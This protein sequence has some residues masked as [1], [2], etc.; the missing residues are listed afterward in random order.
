M[1]KTIKIA[2]YS[3]LL[4]GCCAIAAG[5]TTYLVNKNNKSI[6]HVYVTETAV[7]YSGV[8]SLSMSAA[9]RTQPV[10]LTEA[11]EMTVHG[12]VHIKATVNGRTQTI[13]ETPDIFEY[14]F[15]F[16][17]PRQRQIQS[18][19]QVGYGSGVILSKDG[20][21][22][23]NNHVIDKADDIEVTLNDSRV[24]H[25]SLVGKDENTDLAL[26]KI[27]GDEFPVIPM[28]NSD[29]LKLGE[30]VLAVGNPFNLTSSVTAG[31][32]SA[33]ARKIGIYEGSESIESFIQT[34]A[35]INMGNS[36]G[37]LVNVKGELVGINSALE[38][39]TGTYAGYGFAI[40]TTIVRKVVSDLK[41]YGSV[42][43]AILGIRGGDV[44][45]MRQLDENKEKDFGTLE[46]VYVSEVSDG[47]GALA[48]G[49]KEGDI[50]TAIN[51]KKVKTMTELQ[52]TIVQFSPGDKV[53]VTVLRDK[54]TR[55]I[56]V[57][58]KNF[59]GNTDVVKTSD[60]DNLGAEFKEVPEQTRRQLNIGYGMQ[61]SGLK[62][63]LL[64]KN[65]IQRGFIILKI[66]SRQIKSQDDIEQVYNEAV[67]SPDQVLF[68]TGIY[69]SG[70]RANYAV[71]LDE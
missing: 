64:R 41:E 21:I 37:A 2:L 19:P 33:K 42:Q 10:D 55:K 62:D 67:K 45:S 50:I 43:R 7:P 13:Q 16:A 36:G 28:G 54:K 20:Y 48:A 71:S 34:D 14:F 29:E 12:V 69:P 52:E 51:G 11:A 53:E 57:E 66:N 60:F 18:R 49:L 30:W 58:L 40:P 39:P 61:V 22:V 6:D 56:D 32:V 8:S 15:G 1:K 9:S 68:I 3:L 17:Q 65:G 63:G 35:A 44:A 38:S 5:V 4:I 23:T 70:R 47:G 31:V 24:F 46:G 59:K 27:E 25:A 26:I